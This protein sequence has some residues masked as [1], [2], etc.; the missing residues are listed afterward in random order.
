M[1]FFKKRIGFGEIQPETADNVEM[2][3]PT[4]H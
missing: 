2:G 3:E 4:L 1:P